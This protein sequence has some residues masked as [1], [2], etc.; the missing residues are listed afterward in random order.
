LAATGVT[1]TVTVPITPPDSTLIV[2]VRGERANTCPVDWP[3]T[4]THGSLLD[5]TCDSTSAGLT[6][7]L[8]DS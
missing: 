5:H 1:V 6:F 3:A 7:P 2:A 8:A 4:A